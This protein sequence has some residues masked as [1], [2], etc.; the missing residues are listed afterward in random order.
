MIVDALMEHRGRATRNTMKRCTRQSTQ[1]S[2]C[3]GSARYLQRSVQRK[4][5]SVWPPPPASCATARRYARLL[6]SRWRTGRRR[7]P[8]TLRAAV[9]A[10][11]VA[12]EETYDDFQRYPPGAVPW[13]DAHRHE[14][15]DTV[16][17]MR[18]TMSV[19]AIAS[20]LARSFLRSG[21]GQRNSNSS[22]RLATRAGTIFRSTIWP[23]ECPSA[24]G[25]SR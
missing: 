18:K 25:M 23:E 20:K 3:R 22:L 10:C 2:A 4:P 19:V 6:W 24:S 8:G 1:P 15:Y 14:L 11:I 13:T 7:D 12:C 5:T 16:H 9:K 21:L 17:L